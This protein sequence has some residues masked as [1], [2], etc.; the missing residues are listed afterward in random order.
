MKDNYQQNYVDMYLDEGA[1]LY[2]L[3][4]EIYNLAI[5]D[6]PEFDFRLKHITITNAESFQLMSN[7]NGRQIGKA[8][9]VVGIEG[10]TFHLTYVSNETGKTVYRTYLAQ[11]PVYAV[12]STKNKKVYLNQWRYTVH[13]DANF[14]PKGHVGGVRTVEQDEFDPN[15][16]APAPHQQAQYPDVR[17]QTDY[18]PAPHQMPQYPGVAQSYPSQSY[19]PQ[20]QYGQP[21]QYRGYDNPVYAERPRQFDQFGRLLDYDQY[22]QP[23][24]KDPVYDAYGRPIY[25]DINTGQPLYQRPP[26][27]HESDVY[28][29]SD[30]DGNPLFDNDGQPIMIESEK[31]VNKKYHNSSGERADAFKPTNVVESEQ[32][33]RAQSRA[34]ARAQQAVQNGVPDEK[35]YLIEGDDAVE[36]PGMKNDATDAEDNA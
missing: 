6:F 1:K 7:Q 21:Q 29:A 16:Y 34:L 14:T 31:Y 4:G 22:G 15:Q 8:D 9:A 33:R 28:Q 20:Q 12:D 3:V 35:S 11:C 19:P 18:A 25:F 36:L 26:V 2:Q 24:Y 17:P 10:V 23:M 27:E 32:L 30:E 5:L 13:A